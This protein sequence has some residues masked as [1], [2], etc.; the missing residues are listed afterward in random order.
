MTLLTMYLTIGCFVSLF[1]YFKMEEEI[2]LE[3]YLLLNAD[4]NIRIWFRDHPKYFKACVL[5]VLFAIVFIWPYIL[6]KM[7]QEDDEDDDE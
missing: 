3:A 5:T 6:T 2:S 7:F 1:I 4:E